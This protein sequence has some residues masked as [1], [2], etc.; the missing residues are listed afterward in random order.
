MEIQ[1]HHLAASSIFHGVVQNCFSWPHLISSHLIQLT[2]ILD[3]I[4]M[5]PMA[6]LTHPMTNGRLRLF[7]FGARRF[8]SFSSSEAR[9]VSTRSFMNIMNAEAQ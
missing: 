3:A 9:G 4:G 6:C 8:F 5:R 2:M 1:R 7:A